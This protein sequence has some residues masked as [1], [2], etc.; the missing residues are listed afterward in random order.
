MEILGSRD[1][2]IEGVGVF[3][4]VEWPDGYG[5]DDSDRFRGW[6]N[7]GYEQECSSPCPQISPRYT[8]VIPEQ[9]PAS[10]PHGYVIPQG[11]KDPSLGQSLRRARLQGSDFC[12]Q[13]QL[14]QFFGIELIFR[15]SKLATEARPKNW[16]LESWRGFVPTRPFTTPGRNKRVY[17]TCD[18]SVRYMRQNRTLLARM[19]TAL[20][21]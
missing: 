8:T 15:P 18:Q 17:V 7:N 21:A 10:D 14:A 2:M 5:P 16:K 1:S 20:P 3:A 6:P 12:T 13:E 19:L 4:K 11:Q 9:H